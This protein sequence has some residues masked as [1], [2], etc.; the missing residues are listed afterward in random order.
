MEESFEINNEKSTCPASGFSLFMTA[1]ALVPQQL[2]DDENPDLWVNF[3]RPRVPRT[4]H[5][6]AEAFPG[7]RLVC[8]YEA[9]A[10]QEENQQ[11]A[12]C[13]LLHE[14]QGHAEKDYVVAVRMDDRLAVVCF[15]D[16]Q[17]QLGNIYDAG[18]K[19]QTLYWILKIY[20]V[21]GLDKTA[22]IYIRCGDGTMRLLR[23]H[24]NA[25]P[26]EDAQS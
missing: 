5:I 25:N 6:K 24:L 26:I 12:L 4:Q 9:A 16:G 21:I 19:E 14:A 20:E 13:Y 2:I 23:T 8:L 7:N 15:R 11:H 22:P 1:F 18:T 10:S 17:L 3:L